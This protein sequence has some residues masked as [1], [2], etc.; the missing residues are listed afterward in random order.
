[1]TVT[2]EYFLSNCRNSFSSGHG[3]SELK[4]KVRYWVYH[5]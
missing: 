3:G 4:Q 2:H 1:M 5:R